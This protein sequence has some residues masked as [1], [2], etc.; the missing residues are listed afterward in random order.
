MF[1]VLAELGRVPEDDQ[2]DTWNMGIGLV[3]MVAESDADAS[4]LESEWSVPLLGERLG[5]RMERNEDGRRLGRHH[6]RAASDG[7][8]LDRASERHATYRI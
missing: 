8:E 1:R 3:V 6:H 7:R 5:R 2:W 4:E